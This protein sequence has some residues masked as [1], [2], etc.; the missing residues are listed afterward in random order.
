[1]PDAFD[2]FVY[3]D[4]TFVVTDDP[5]HYLHDLVQQFPT[6]ETGL[7][8]APFFADTFHLL[9]AFLFAK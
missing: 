7:R 1:M 8:R 2:T 6:E 3:P 5:K 4:F 9:L